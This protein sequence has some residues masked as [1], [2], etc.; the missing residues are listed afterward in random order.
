[1]KNNLIIM[2]EKENSNLNSREL[3][4]KALGEVVTPP[5]NLKDVR[6]F[7][8]I[9]VEQEGGRRISIPFIRS[10]WIEFKPPD[11]VI[12]HLYDGTIRL[13]GYR[14][15][16]LYVGLHEQ[17]AGYIIEQDEIYYDESKNS[18]FVTDIEVEI[19]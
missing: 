18:P 1:M 5:V 13:K 3:F 14:M 6:R 2:E 16:A 8:H 11:E 12:M 17:T 9:D 7:T 10:R 19:D 15:E 4:E